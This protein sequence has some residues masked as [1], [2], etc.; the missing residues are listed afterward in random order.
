M[1]VCVDGIEIDAELQERDEIEESN[2]VR[3]GGRRKLEVRWL[4]VCVWEREVDI[5]QYVCGHTLKDVRFKTQP[6]PTHTHTLSLTGG[7]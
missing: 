4:C 7:H 6:K 2:F 5:C 3:F 1:C